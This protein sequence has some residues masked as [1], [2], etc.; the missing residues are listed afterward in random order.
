MEGKPG[1]AFFEKR[2]VS[3][4]AYCRDAHGPPATK[5][6]SVRE[7]V[8]FHW[9]W[10]MVTLHRK[11]KLLPERIARLNQIPDWTWFLPWERKPEDQQQKTE[12]SRIAKKTQKKKK[13]REQWCVQCERAHVVFLVTLARWR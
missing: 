6:S 3:Y 8:L 2:C 11:N 10:R 1:S 7:H 9:R 12:L 13:S 5:R 4:E